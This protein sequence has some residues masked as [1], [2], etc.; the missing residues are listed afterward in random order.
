[1]GGIGRATGH[2]D[3]RCSVSG[4]DFQ[5]SCFQRFQLIALAK[6]VLERALHGRRQT[7]R[8]GCSKS[9]IRP[10]LHRVVS[11][12]LIPRTRRACQSEVFS[13]AA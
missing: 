11:V 10:E 5:H 2:G 8:R 3:G 9:K 1:M 6:V 4:E 7:R 12:A 13:F